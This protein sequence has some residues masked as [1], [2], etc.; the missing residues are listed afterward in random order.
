MDSKYEKKALDDNYA[1]AQQ[2]IKKADGTGLI[3][4]DMRDWYSSLCLTIL[5]INGSTL[6]PGPISSY[7]PRKAYYQVIIDPAATALGEHKTLMELTLNFI[8]LGKG[9][10]G[11]LGAAVR[12]GFRDKV[13]M[14]RE[15]TEYRSIDAVIA[16]VTKAELKTVSS[17]MESHQKAYVACRGNVASFLVQAGVNLIRMTHHWSSEAHKEYTAMVKV[18]GLSELISDDQ[19]RP[20]VYLSVHP[21]PLPVLE[22]ERKKP[23]TQAEDA[24]IETVEKR[25]AVTPAGYGAAGACYAAAN[26]LLAEEFASS[27][28]WESITGSLEAEIKA[29]EDA[30]EEVSRR[31]ILK[32]AEAKACIRASQV[33]VTKVKAFSVAIKPVLDNPVAYCVLAS[34]F[35]VQRAVVDLRPHTGAMCMLTAYI[36]SKV[37][38]TLAKSPALKKFRSQHSVRVSKA[39][40]ALEDF[41]GSGRLSSVMGAL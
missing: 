36:Y 15:C 38:G 25:K 4:A 41:E 5:D 11:F 18:M 3:D 9:I 14:S 10:A 2:K 8:A 23:R 33:M 13:D 21:C 24:L 17:Y 39:Q 12:S 1:D 26:D 40:E 34:A 19:L 32:H 35:N 28:Y 20:L 30:K 6:I 7:I 37:R 31:L 29:K 27:A 22:T 16:K